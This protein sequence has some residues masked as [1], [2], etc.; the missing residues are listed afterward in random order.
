MAADVSAIEKHSCPACGAQ[1]EWH[2]GR[3]KLICPFCGTESP[4]VIDRRTGQAVELDL[5][6]ALRDL[7]DSERGWQAARRSVQCQS[8]RAVMVF[9]PERVGQNCEFCGSPALVDYQEIRA[10]IRPLSLLPFK[11]DLHEARNALR[12]W[13]GRQ[14]FA[15]NRLRR[16]AL[17]DMVKGVYIPYWT[18]D[19]AARCP[20][21]ADA[22]YYYYVN[23]PGRD[24]KGRPIVIRERRVRWEPASG[25]IEHRFDDE[26]VPGTRGIPHALLRRIEPFPTGDLVP[27]DTAFLAGHVVEHYQI[28]LLEA[29][30]A[31]EDRMHAQLEQLAAAAVP[32]DTHRNLR[33][34]PEYSGR[35]FKHI[36][37][38]VYLLT[39]LYGRKAYQVLVNGYTGA[40]AG[41]RP[42]SV[43]KI[44]GAV[45]LALVAVGIFIALQN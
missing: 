35:T 22:G 16:S 12:R 9:E 42:Y 18:F 1:A 7:P 10:P 25:I 26:L 24:A 20:W 19:A 32:G 40:V 15:P 4:A 21:E 33:I 45:L 36:L 8:C 30:R 27:Y 2:A 14:W 39:Y 11:V 13:W 41:G 3:Q 37:V 38:P 6:A 34:H 29:A 31:S 28:V 5:A 43:W 17:I 23:V 44:L